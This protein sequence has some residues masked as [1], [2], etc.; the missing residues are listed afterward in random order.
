VKT[1]AHHFHPSAASVV[2]VF[3]SAAL[4]IYLAAQ[5]FRE[6]EETEEILGKLVTARTGTLFL[7]VFFYAIFA[8][9]PFWT[10]S[11]WLG[12]LRNGLFC[13]EYAAV[14]LLALFVPRIVAAGLLFVLV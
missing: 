5:R 2:V 12:L 1:V 14:G 8:N 13:L 4:A 7:F 3:G 6:I 9:V 10:A 11:P